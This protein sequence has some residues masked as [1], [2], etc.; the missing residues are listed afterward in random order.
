MKLKVTQENLHK[1][2]Q[3]VSRVAVS[4][5]PTL[6]ILSNI[7]IKADKNLI[8]DIAFTNNDIRLFDKPANYL[9]SIFTFKIY[10]YASFIP[11][12]AD[13]SA[14]FANQG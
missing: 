3:V 5:T 8:Y 13:I 6:P 4:R 7:L 2:L 14:T 1:A 9:K 10:D 11:I 12:D